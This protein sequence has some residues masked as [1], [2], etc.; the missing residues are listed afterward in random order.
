MLFSELIYFSLSR[1]QSWLNSSWQDDIAVSVKAYR[2][3][4]CF[5][6]SVAFP[7]ASAVLAQS[8]VLIFIKWIN[9]GNI[10]RS[11]SLK[12]EY[13]SITQGA[14]FDFFLN[15]SLIL[16]C[17]PP[18]LSFFSPS[19]PYLPSFP[20]ET[21]QTLCSDTFQVGIYFKS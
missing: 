2:V 19:S 6:L 21:Q 1:S 5:W 11:H 4:V 18:F 13:S 15:S 9:E 8:R 20:S 17:L 10:A 3:Q 7:D 14:L 12:F 16:S